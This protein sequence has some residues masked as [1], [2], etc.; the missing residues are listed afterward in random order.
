MMKKGKPIS[1]SEVCKQRDFNIPG[2]VIDIFNELIVEKFDG[3][4]AV[5]HQDSA[6]KLITER[7]GVKSEEIY[8][9]HWLEVESIFRN[10]GWKVSYDKPAYNEFYKAY[11]L[12]S[13]P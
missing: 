12:F 11:F 13:K 5:V 7:L 6:I 3:K 8:D 2:E 9:K 4:T 1:P 10:C